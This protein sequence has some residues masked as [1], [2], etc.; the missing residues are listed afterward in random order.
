MPT[1]GR[2][3]PAYSG[4]RSAHPTVRPTSATPRPPWTE[5]AASRAAQVPVVVAVAVA[6]ATSPATRHAP[7]GRA[8]SSSAATGPP[9]RAEP[10]DRPGGAASAELELGAP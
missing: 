9:T 7:A 8:A 4:R 1:T 2:G 5:T 3:W 6:T 10:T